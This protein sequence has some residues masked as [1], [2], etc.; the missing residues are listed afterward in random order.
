[1]TNLDIIVND[2]IA[3]NIFTKSQI[4]AYLLEGDIPLK[5]YKQWFDSGFVV[6]RGETARLKT[7]LWLPKKSKKDSKNTK[8]S[9]QIKNYVLVSTYL[10]T[11]DQVVKID[12]LHAG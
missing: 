4:E 11:A 9:E 3:A 7:R 1:M 5:S 6:K 8:E 10:F 2:A 12:S